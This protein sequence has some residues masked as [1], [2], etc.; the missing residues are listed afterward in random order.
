MIK[1]ALG[2]KK[3]IIKLQKPDFSALR[4]LIK[5]SFPDAPADHLLSYLDQDKDEISLNSDE[6][7]HIMLTGLKINNVYI[8][9]ACRRPSRSPT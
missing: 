6:D 7:L 5:Q 4:A 9:R 2:T 1:L 8:N 3:K